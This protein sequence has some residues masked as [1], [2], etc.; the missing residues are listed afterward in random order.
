MSDENSNFLRNE[1]KEF[2][3]ATKL[4]IESK[5]SEMDHEEQ[6]LTSFAERVWNLHHFSLQLLSEQNCDEEKKYNAR[7]IK[8]L[9]EAP[10][11]HGSEKD[12][13]SLVSAADSVKNKNEFTAIKTIMAN[14][15][16]DQIA[17]EVLLD[18]L[19]VIYKELAA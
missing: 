10:L 13:C 1:L 15:I 9:T 8:D 3:H 2:I 18:N 7:I 4:L 14:F 19:S 12:T 6:A 5:A 11:Y 17:A 16:K